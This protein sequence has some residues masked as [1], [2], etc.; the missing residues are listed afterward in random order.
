MKLSKFTAQKWQ[1]KRAAEKGQ[2]TVVKLLLDKNA[3][4]ES[5]DDEYGQTPLSRLARRRVVKL[6]LEK[7][8]DIDSK[9][10]DGRAP[11]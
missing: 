1:T 5:K 4:V 2:E 3:D 8:A 9:D 11:L 7:N 10:D 6:L